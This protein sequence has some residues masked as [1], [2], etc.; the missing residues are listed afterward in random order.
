LRGTLICADKTLI[1]TDDLINFGHKGTLEWTRLIISE[2]IEP[3]A[4]GP[5]SV[6]LHEDSVT[7][8]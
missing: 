3:G 6:S 4:L 7:F 5:S 2:L 1:K 8:G